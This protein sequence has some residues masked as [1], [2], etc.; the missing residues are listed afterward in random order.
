MSEQPAPKKT[1]IAY[2]DELTGVYNRRFLTKFL[3]E[4]FG[5]FKRLAV[6]M[7]DIDSFKKIND[8]YG[9]LEGDALLVSFCGVLKETVADNG[10]IIRYG[11]D[12][13]SIILPEK[14]EKE[15]AVLAEKILNDIAARP[16]KGRDE[17]K[18]H[19]VT[20]S[21][22]IAIYPDDAGKPAD[23]FDKA[24]EALYSSKRMGK[25]RISTSRQVD[26]ETI[27]LNKAMKA[28]ALPVFVGR[29]DELASLKAVFDASGKDTDRAAVVFGGRGSG[30]S[31]FLDE[32]ILNTAD[33]RTVIVRLNL[34]ELD[35]IKPYGAVTD[36]IIDYLKNA[37]K[38]R[39]T[40]IL[41]NVRTESIAELTNFAYEF[42]TFFSAKKGEPPEVSDMERRRNLF[43]GLSAIFKGM[44]GDG[45]LVLGLD[46]M[47][48][49][50]LASLGLIEYLLKDKKT[51]FFLC[52]T[53]LDGARPRTNIRLREFRLGPLAKDDV[54]NIISDTFENIQINPAL[55]DIFYRKTAGNPLFVIEA[56]KL[57]ID[58]KKAFF[59]NGEWILMA[60]RETDIPASVEDIEK[61]RLEMFDKDERSIMT[62]AAFLGDRFNLD[63]LKKISQKKDGYIL[64]AVNNARRLDMI[65][66]EDFSGAAGFG[67]TNSEIRAI[68]CGLATALKAKEIQKKIAVT[69]E[70]YDK[71][72][73]RVSPAELVMR[74]RLAG[75]EA[76]AQGY[77][78][79]MSALTSRVFSPEEMSAYIESL[80]V[81]TE[82]ASVEEMLERPLN[83]ESKSMVSD[84]LV[85]LRGAIETSLLYPANNEAR[86]EHKKEAFRQLSRILRHERSFTLSQADNQLLVNG[87]ELSDK[88]LRNTIGLAYVKMLS[89]HRISSITIKQGLSEQDLG[90]FLEAITQK[91]GDLVKAGGFS[92]LFA[93]NNVLSIKIDEVRYE[94]AHK[95]AGFF[96][97]ATLQEFL[98]GT[99]QT[100]LPRPGSKDELKE[101]VEE[102]YGMA[103]RAAGGASGPDKKAAVVL[104]SLQRIGWPVAEMRSELEEVLEAKGLPKAE[105]AKLL[106][107]ALRSG[108]ARISNVGDFVKNTI[109][110]EVGKDVPLD[111]RSVT[112][113]LLE[114]DKENTVFRLTEALLDEAAWADKDK[115]QL[116]L[117]H[118]AEIIDIILLEEKYNLLKRIIPQIQKV[119]GR[120]SDD[121]NAA[122]VCE[123]FIKIF[124][125]EETVKDPFESYVRKRKAAA[126]IQGLGKIAIA[127]LRFRLEEQDPYR[128]KSIISISGYMG[129]TAIVPY[130]APLAKHSDHSVKE[131]LVMALQRLGGLESVKVL[132]LLL[133]DINEQFRS[134]VLDTLISMCGRTAV[135]ELKKYLSDAQVGHSIKKIID[136]IEKA[137][138]I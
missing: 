86:L 27:V 59:R 106:G 57:L 10:F 2:I 99:T 136:A 111:F 53:A 104:D 44:A 58:K 91:E 15:T 122:L 123:P 77:V 42:G 54:K 20:A 102:L 81:D 36:S 45:A 13:F 105:I 62:D 103:E 133:S 4:G 71:A 80:P 18:S 24:D 120:N 128:L 72:G 5:K 52:A 21:M 38:E 95:T 93:E 34:K 76:R 56:L 114:R 87:E 109:G 137:N 14:N 67:F 82:M 40:E 66:P 134:Y 17:A 124:E 65:R 92:K 41:K 100:T 118:V 132:V 61:D 32:F 25:N 70:D 16:L 28:L 131:E 43:R 8:A 1:D 112:R 116:V 84:I 88:R 46:N 12:E 50:D 49:I 19:V 73:G 135:P 29:K 110:I 47:H 55:L 51:R 22:G 63:M 127:G 23:L 11:G 97:Y 33:R 138:S 107:D 125:S 69:L 113:D 115:V 119:L 74:Y 90:F 83:D 129:E 75:E 98:S 26:E 121:L 3:A 9:H 31:R 37:T 85:A 126:A 94:K 117:K 35:S 108:L 60:R 48:W 79:K 78:E 39:Q 68:F 89:N 101:I 96:K 6:C 7:M 64:D 30:K 130:L